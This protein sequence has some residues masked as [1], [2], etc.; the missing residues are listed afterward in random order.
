[1]NTSSD[2]ALLSSLVT[3]IDELESRV[4][5]MAEQYG[6]TP[7]SAIAGELFAAERAL[8][9]ARRSLDRASGHLEQL[10]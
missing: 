2:L 4:T 1:M 3:Q 10:R 6:E 9:S 7:D 5:A 8:T